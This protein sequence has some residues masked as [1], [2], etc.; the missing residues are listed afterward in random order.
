MASWN[1]T[2]KMAQ[3][4]PSG[5]RR[6]MFKGSCSMKGVGAGGASAGADEVEGM[7]DDEAG[8]ADKV[9]GADNIA[10]NRMV[11]GAAIMVLLATLSRAHN[12]LQG[13]G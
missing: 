5:L 3:F 10:R 4:E 7:V 1:R 8:G 11:Y 6:G 13:Y 9:G 12:L 2:A